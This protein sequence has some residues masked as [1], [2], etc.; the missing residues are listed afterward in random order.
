MFGFG[1]SKSFD[2]NKDIPDCSGKTILVT[3]G[4]F[5]SKRIIN[6]VLTVS[7]GN[8]GLGRATCEAIAP[9]SPKHIYLAA[10]SASKANDTIEA[11]K[12]TNPKLSISFLQCDLGD[13]DSVVAAAKEVTSDSDRLDLLFCNAGVMALPPSLTKSGYEVQFGTNHVGHALLIKLLLPLLERTANEPGSDVRIIALSSLGHNQTPSA[14][15]NFDTLKTDQKE[16]MTW[17]RYGQSKLANIL[18]VKELAK[19]YPSIKSVAVHPGFVATNLATTC[20]QESIIIRTAMTL[21]S[22]IPGV[23]KSP[24]EGAYNQLWAAFAP[25]DVVGSGEY[26]EPV[27]VGGKASKKANNPELAS[28]LWT[29]TET[30]LN[31]YTLAE[32]A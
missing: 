28:R 22:C 23:M 6:P 8:I 9:Q 25:K 13:L 21:V 20:T 31:G 12:R 1:G 2:V 11:I 7:E 14:G 19:R 4:M 24:D 15:I 26:Y 27:G 30:E 16:V 3:G 32:K 5:F 29:W 10:R 17:S 18:Y